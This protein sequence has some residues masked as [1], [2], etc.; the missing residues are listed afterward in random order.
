M[1]L[2]TDHD[3]YAI[4][5]AT[6]G[7]PW[8]DLQVSP[9]LRLLL[10]NLQLTDSMALLRLLGPEFRAR[11]MQTSASAPPPPVV[12]KIPEPEPVIVPALPPQAQLTDRALK[13]A[14][15]A[16]HWLDDTMTWACRRSPMTPPFFLTAGLVWALGLAIAR[17]CAAPLHKPI[18][19]HL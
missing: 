3:I 13:A 12:L 1:P 7:L 17:R 2:L 8:K 15:G 16:G 4:A 10:D 9:M 14:E 18:Y 5:R 6:A 11:V 19:P